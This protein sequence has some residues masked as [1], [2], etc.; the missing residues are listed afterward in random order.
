MDNGKSGREACRRRSL[1]ASLLPI[2]IMILP[3]VISAVP[4]AIG[5]PSEGDV[6]SMK[7]PLAKDQGAVC[8]VRNRR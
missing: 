2:A 7:S 8:E 1:L 5:T 6:S 3:L 4:L